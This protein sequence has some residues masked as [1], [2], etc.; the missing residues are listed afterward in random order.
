MRGE[1]SSSRV[2]SQIGRRDP[3]YTPTLLALRD[4]NG[5]PV[6]QQTNERLDLC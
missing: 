1:G 6:L 3:L 4:G 2:L 5:K